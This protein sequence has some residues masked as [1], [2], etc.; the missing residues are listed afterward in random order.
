M[1]RTRSVAR[2]MNE[3]TKTESGRNRLTGKKETK[4]EEDTG[5]KEREEQ[6]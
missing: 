4:K 2:G 1:E 6:R 5:I 3:R